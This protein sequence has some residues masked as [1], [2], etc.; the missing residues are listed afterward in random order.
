MS[1]IDIIIPTYKPDISF[2]RLID[3][4]ERQTITPSHIIIMNTEKKYWDELISKSREN[5][6]EKY[7]NII[8]E[9]VSKPEFDHGGT[10]NKGVSLSS[11]EFFL[12]MTQDAFPKNKMLLATLSNVLTEDV[13]AAY[14][15][16]YPIWRRDIQE[17]LIIPMSI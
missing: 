10:R 12:M 14:A 6:L 4:L 3:D 11:A 2:L 8:L 9:H 17:S 13:A 1:T 7:D 16:Q 15:R 5:P